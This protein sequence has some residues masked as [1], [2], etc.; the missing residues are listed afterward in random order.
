LQLDI[1]KLGYSFYKAI[2][3]LKNF[4]LEKDNKLRDYCQ[5][6]GNVF[7]YERKIGSWML[8]L[9]MDI[10]DYKKANELMKEMKEKFSDY[11]KNF[12]LML[13][14]NEPKGELDLTQQL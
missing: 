12:D 7:H 9:E 6:L 2:I 8:E 13:I 14:T 4:S 5:N 3:Y 10:E 11:I 1:N